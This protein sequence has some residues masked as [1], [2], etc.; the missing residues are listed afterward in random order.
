MNYEFLHYYNIDNKNLYTSIC[1]RCIDINYKNFMGV[2]IEFLDNKKDY[3]Y[4]C[5]KA[6]KQLFYFFNHNIKIINHFTDKFYDIVKHYYF[7]I[8]NDIKLYMELVIYII[9]QHKIPYGLD[10]DIL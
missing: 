1:S 7:Y 3:L 9:N 10:I 4:L 5:K 6:L 8:D 2:K